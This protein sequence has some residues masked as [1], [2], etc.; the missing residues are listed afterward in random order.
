[1]KEMNP[2]ADALWNLLVLVSSLTVMCAGLRV[3]YKS[4]KAKTQGDPELK[5]SAERAAEE[6]ENK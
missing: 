5:R 4:H 6:A 3:I 1:M 2:T